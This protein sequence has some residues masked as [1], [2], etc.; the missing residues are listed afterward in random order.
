MVSDLLTLREKRTKRF[1]RKDGESEPS[2][3]QDR[4]MGLRPS[5]TRMS[6]SKFILLGGEGAAGGTEPGKREV[7]TEV[8]ESIDR[9]TGFLT[10]TN[11]APIN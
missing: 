10:R 4:Q 9:N 1:Y 2:L 5:S 8:K 11:Y 6:A 3:P 7:R